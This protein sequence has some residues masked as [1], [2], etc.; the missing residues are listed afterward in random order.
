MPVRL[1]VELGRRS[2]LE[3]AERQPT[4]Q[5][6]DAGRLFCSTLAYAHFTQFARRLAAIF[7]G[8]D[9]HCSKNLREKSVFIL[10]SKWV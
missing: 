6:P 9:G 1:G 10:C 3:G 7:E 2:G 5:T 4:L 8:V